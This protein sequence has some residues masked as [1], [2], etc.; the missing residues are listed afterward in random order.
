[1]Y[2]AFVCFLTFCFYIIGKSK[3]D[4]K[5]INKAHKEMLEFLRLNDEIIQA[6]KRNKTKAL[7]KKTIAMI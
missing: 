1:M 6:K 4:N 2:I 5:K 7:K 3:Y